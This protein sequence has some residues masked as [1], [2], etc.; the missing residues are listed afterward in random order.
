MN[1]SAPEAPLRRTCTR[2]HTAVSAGAQHT[3]LWA[4]ARAGCSHHVAGMGVAVQRNESSSQGHSRQHVI[5]RAPRTQQRGVGSVHNHPAHTRTLSAHTQHPLLARTQ[6]PL[7]RA[8]STQQRG[9]GSVHNHP[10]HTRT[11]SAHTQHP[12][13]ARTQHPLQRAPSTR[14][15]HATARCWQC[16]QSSCRHPHSQRAH[17]T[18][19]PART[20]HA[21]QQRCWL[22]PQSQCACCLLALNSAG[23]SLVLRGVDLQCVWFVP[24][25]EPD[26]GVRGDFLRRHRL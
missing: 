7:Q 23:D 3:A 5:T 21:H 19:T 6:H 4:R 14:T 15:T 11:L 17:P 20:Q 16:P 10:A 12:L 26:H 13:L 24:P 22:C 1:A 25:S 2:G 8:P 9:V 18:P